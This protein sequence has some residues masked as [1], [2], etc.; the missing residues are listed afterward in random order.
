MCIETCSFIEQKLIWEF[1]EGGLKKKIEIP[2]SRIN[3]L[4]VTYLETGDGTLDIEV[5]LLYEHQEMFFND[6]MFL[7][8]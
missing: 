4:K 3:G 8:S 6:I 7:F 2:W 1:L 5:I